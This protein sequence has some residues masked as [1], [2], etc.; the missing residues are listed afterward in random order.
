[1][2]TLAIIALTISAF[3]L[4]GTAYEIEP[5]QEISIQHNKLKVEPQPLGIVEVLDSRGRNVAVGQEGV[6]VYLK[7]KERGGF[8]CGPMTV[9]V[10][11]KEFV[12]RIRPHHGPVCEE[13]QH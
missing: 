12:F 1:L 11:N 13:H 9:R 4:N 10:G 6:F 2:V 3:E 5:D 7:A 8:V